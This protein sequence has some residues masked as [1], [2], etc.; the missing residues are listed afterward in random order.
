MLEWLDEQLIPILDGQSTL[1]AIDLFQAH[2]IAEVLYT[3]RD[4]DITVSLIPGGC[5]G[6]VQPLDV[7]INRPFK[8]ILKV[9]TFST[10]IK[11]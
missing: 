8:D 1:L 5:T 7:S 6:L 11:K 9:S 10:R 2:Q 3:F 4:N